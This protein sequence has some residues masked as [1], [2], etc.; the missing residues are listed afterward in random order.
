[1]LIGDRSEPIG[2]FL[3][4][5]CYGSQFCAQGGLE[6]AIG[7]YNRMALQASIA[8]ALVSPASVGRIS[9]V[10]L[11]SALF[12]DE[13]GNRHGH[14]RWLSELLGLRKLWSVRRELTPEADE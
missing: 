13:R 14:T 6:H 11:C 9:S 2:R 12:S 8:T 5:G 10:C 3:L 1:M 4:F 7:A